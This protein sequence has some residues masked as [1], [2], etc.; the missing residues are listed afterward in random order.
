MKPEYRL[1]YSSSCLIPPEK[2]KTNTNKTKGH[3][4]KTEDTKKPKSKQIT[5]TCEKEPLRVYK[6]EGN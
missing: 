6:K 5:A 2:P 1:M 3:D 4:T